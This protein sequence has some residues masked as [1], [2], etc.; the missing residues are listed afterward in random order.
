MHQVHQN[1]DI[2]ISHS[3]SNFRPSMYSP[4][5]SF[6]HCED[7]DFKTQHMIQRHKTGRKSW[8]SLKEKKEAVWPEYLEEALLEGKRDARAYQS[9]KLMFF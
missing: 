4:S 7:D 2:D 5:S 9:T 8:K 3:H 1:A 6:D